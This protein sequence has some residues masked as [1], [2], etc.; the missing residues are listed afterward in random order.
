MDSKKQA[1]I[2]SA[3]QRLANHEIPILETQVPSFLRSLIPPITAAQL[4]EFGDECAA[5]AAQAS[6]EWDAQHAPKAPAAA[7]TTPK[8]QS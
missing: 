1:Y 5:T 2:A 4:K 6:D 7:F 3:F 8:V